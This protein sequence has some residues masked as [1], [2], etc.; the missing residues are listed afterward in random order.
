MF[1]K[2]PPERLAA[3]EALD[4][5]GAAYGELL[6]TDRTMLQGQLQTYAASVVD[7]DVRESR[8]AATAGSWTTSSG[9]RALTAHTARAVLRQGHAHERPRRDGATRGRTSR[10]TRGPLG[11]PSGCTEDGR[12]RALS[13]FPQMLSN[14]S[15]VGTRSKPGGH[16]DS[17]NE[18][19]CGR[20]SITSIALFM[21]VLDN[22][23][24]STALPVIRVD[25]GASIEQLEWIVNA[26]TLTFA[27]FLLTGAALGDRFGRKRMFMIGV[28]HLHGRIRVGGARA[29]DRVADRRAC[30]PGHR[31]RDR[32]ASHADDPERGG[33]AAPPRRRARRLVGHRGLRRRDGAARRRRRGRR[34]LLAVDLLAE[35]PGR[36]AS[37]SRSR[38]S[39]ASRTGRTRRSTFPASRSAAPACSGSSGAS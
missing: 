31:R 10:R 14:Q 6:E 15:L 11:S 28:A 8:R 38:R 37:C 16:D 35:R 2:P 24:V 3:S 30:L 27:V 5:M 25:L 9:S 1:R 34:H 29:V 36:A 4:A 21:V 26:Y 33:L 22:L 32:H 17:R 39:C 19:G 20:S 18:H 7:D 23:V 13:L 12:V